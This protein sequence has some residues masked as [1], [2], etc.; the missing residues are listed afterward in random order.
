[1]RVWLELSAA[2]FYTHPLSQIIDH[3][4]T[5]R[6]LARRLGLSEQQRVL[7]VFRV[8]TLGRAGQVAPPCLSAFC[9]QPIP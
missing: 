1:M 9:G 8:R 5:E 2:G 4:V 6:E 7:S 3:E